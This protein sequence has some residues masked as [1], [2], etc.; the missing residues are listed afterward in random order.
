MY[1]G[2]FRRGLN[3][4]PVPC[5]EHQ[6]LISVHLAAVAR[7]NE[8]DEAV[9]KSRGQGGWEVWHEAAKEARRVCREILAD[10]DRHRQ[11]HGC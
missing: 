10:L 8:A 9:A 7:L 2:G 4:G 11:E 5:E 1:G 3:N 6:R